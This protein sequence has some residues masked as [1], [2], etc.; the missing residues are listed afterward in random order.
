MPK[1][2]TGKVLN[3]TELYADPAKGDF[4][5]TDDLF[6]SS[7]VTNLS[8][9][10]SERVDKNFSSSVCNRDTVENDI[11]VE[12]LSTCSVEEIVGS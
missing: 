11:T 1:K 9:S 5:V 8:F 3:T 4:S 10:L 12:L 7:L 6:L 2:Y